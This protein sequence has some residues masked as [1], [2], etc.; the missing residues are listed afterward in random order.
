METF[1]RDGTGF[2][3]P[4]ARTNIYEDFAETYMNYVR[5]PQR[6]LFCSPEKYEFMRNEIFSGNEYTSPILAYLDYDSI[7]RQIEVTGNGTWVVATGEK[8]A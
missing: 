8:I 3:S 1:A 2:V 5:D 4:Y 6:L 7:G